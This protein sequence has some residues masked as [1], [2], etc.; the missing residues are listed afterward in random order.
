MRS[1]ASARK[2]METLV[3][4]LLLKDKKLFYFL[5]SGEWI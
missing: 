4:R 1:R 5:A 2:L 3:S